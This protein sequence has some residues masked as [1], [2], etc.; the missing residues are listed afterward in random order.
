VACN[1]AKYKSPTCFHCSNLF[2]SMNA[3]RF[4]CVTVFALRLCTYLL[5]PSLTLNDDRLT[6]R[7]SIGKSAGLAPLLR[8]LFLLYLL[9]SC[10]IQPI[11]HPCV[12]C[13]R[14]SNASQSIH[15]PFQKFPESPYQMSATGCGN[16]V[17]GIPQHSIYVTTLT[18]TTARCSLEPS[19]IQ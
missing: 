7:S 14:H 16:F 12:K 13:C 17:V 18:L 19:D 1:W 6:S 5:L 15:I 10:T 4:I 9:I 2:K 3:G 8:R 11:S